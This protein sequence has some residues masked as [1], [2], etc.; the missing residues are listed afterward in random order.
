[1]GDFFHGMLKFLIHQIE[2]GFNFGRILSDL[3]QVLNN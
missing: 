3:C 1:M 2:F